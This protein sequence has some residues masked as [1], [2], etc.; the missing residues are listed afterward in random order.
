MSYTVIT[1]NNYSKQG[2]LYV[3]VVYELH[4]ELCIN[5]KYKYIYETIKKDQTVRSEEFQFPFLS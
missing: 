2:K 5:I 3:C 1:V 4:V